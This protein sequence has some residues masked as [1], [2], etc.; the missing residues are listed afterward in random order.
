MYRLLNVGT[1]VRDYQNHKTI[2]LNGTYGHP[3]IHVLKLYMYFNIPKLI[4][5][6][7]LYFEFLMSIIYKLQYFLRPDIVYYNYYIQV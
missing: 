2:V 1:T 5:R 3:S 6:Y 7:Y 4:I